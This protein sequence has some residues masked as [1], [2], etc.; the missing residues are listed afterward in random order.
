RGVELVEEALRLGADAVGGI[1]HYEHTREMGVES[2]K[3]AFRLAGK[4]DRFVDIHCDET[5]DPGSRFLEVVAAEA[6]RT[7]MGRRVTAS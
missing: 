7:G 5:D 2:V 4:Y 1:P 6:I 3:E